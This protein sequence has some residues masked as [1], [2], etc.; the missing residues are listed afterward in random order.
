MNNYPL[1][2]ARAVMDTETAQPAPS[3]TLRQQIQALQATGQ[4][5]PYGAELARQLGTSRQR[6]H[7]L[8]T[9]LGIPLPPGPKGAATTG[10]PFNTK[11][12]R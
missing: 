8:T 12:A 3:L 10:H 9:A 7:Q 4:P 11:A 5:L 1:D 2:P 6:I